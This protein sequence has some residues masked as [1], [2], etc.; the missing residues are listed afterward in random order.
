MSV[1]PLLTVLRLLACAT[2]SMGSSDILFLLGFGLY[3][4]VIL[5]LTTATAEVDAILQN[6][7]EITLL[8]HTE[9]SY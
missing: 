6:V 9:L 7:L 5:V 4:V 1:S 3:L 8:T 2:A